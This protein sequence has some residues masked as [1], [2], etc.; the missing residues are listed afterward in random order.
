MA[1][2]QHRRTADFTEAVPCKEVLTAP[3]RAKLKKRVV[4][5]EKP[6]QKTDAYT[7]IV[8]DFTVEIFSRLVLSAYLGLASQIYSD[9]KRKPELHLR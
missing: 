6:W 9:L 8:K 1:A 5:G 7:R 4:Q 3:V 2:V